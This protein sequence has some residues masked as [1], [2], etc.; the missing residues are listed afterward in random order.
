MSPAG[1]NKKGGRRN[2][3]LLKLEQMRTFIRG[4]QCEVLNRGNGSLET[5]PTG[6]NCHMNST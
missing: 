4:G 3:V 5:C 1:D 6:G 2:L